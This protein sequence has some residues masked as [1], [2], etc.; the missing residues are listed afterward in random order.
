MTAL[1]K[2]FFKPSA[3]ILPIFLF[4]LLHLL[5]AFVSA[6]EPH[7]TD[8][9]TNTSVAVP[10]FRFD[11]NAPYDTSSIATTGNLRASSSAK[12]HRNLAVAAEWRPW[13][14]SRINNIEIVHNLCDADWI[15]AVEDA[16]KAWSDAS[17]SV[18][19]TVTAARCNSQVNGDLTYIPWKIHLVYGTCGRDCCGKAD[20]EYGW[21][22]NGEITK[23]QSLVRLDPDCFDGDWPEG[24]QYLAC[25]EVSE[26]ISAFS[27]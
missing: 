14:S 3:F 26:P 6:S 5:P 10:K 19:L 2:T 9:N 1:S 20:V 13:P 7:F 12:Q 24:K 16:A 22:G 18:G 11:T 23:Y 25:H 21:R 17:S 27:S 4:T 8:L 15:K